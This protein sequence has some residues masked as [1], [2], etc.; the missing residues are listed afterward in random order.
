[1]RLFCVATYPT[2]DEAGSLQCGD[3]CCWRRAV[4][5]ISALRYMGQKQATRTV[6]VHG[7]KPRES[8]DARWVKNKAP[9]FQSPLQICGNEF[10]QANKPWVL[11]TSFRAYLLLKTILFVI[12]WTG[13]SSVTLNICTWWP[14]T[15]EI[16]LLE[17]YVEGHTV[18]AIH[19]VG[20]TDTWH[21]R[22]HNTCS[23]PFMY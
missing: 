17:V 10:S 5:R 1:M 11:G 2:G 9:E 18:L 21:L 7:Y 15:G 13:F 19:N 3:A 14:E 22:S 6:K 16:K 20:D 8:K 23:I 4:M 12:I